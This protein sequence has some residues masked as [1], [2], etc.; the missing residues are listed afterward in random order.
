[1]PDEVIC[2][3]TIIPSQI[4]SVKS[5]IGETSRPFRIYY[6]AHLRPSAD[7]GSVGDLY[8]TQGGTQIF[9]KKFRQDGITT[10]WREVGGNGLQIPHPLY[11]NMML[12][13]GLCHSYPHWCRKEAVDLSKDDIYQ[14]ARWFWEDYGP[15]SSARPIDLTIDVEF[16]E[17]GSSSTPIDLTM[18]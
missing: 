12:K 18:D 13:G 8:I 5:R 3:R 2:I 15:G 14:A 7:M 6:T 11:P 17:H 1:M 10:T 9:W 16:D 4:F